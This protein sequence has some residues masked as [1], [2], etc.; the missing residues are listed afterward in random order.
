MPYQNA[1]DMTSLVDDGI[2]PQ[3]V[4]GIMAKTE[5]AVSNYP[6]GY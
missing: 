1:E 3:T 2:A 6:F 5:I 4:E